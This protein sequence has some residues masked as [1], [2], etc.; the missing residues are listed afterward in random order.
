MEIDNSFPYAYRHLI[1]K[2]KTDIACVREHAFISQRKQE[3]Y[4][5]AQCRVQ[6]RLHSHIFKISNFKLRLHLI[7]YDQ[8]RED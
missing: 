8:A 4:V 5:T 6:L 7:R 1:L 2:G 3:N